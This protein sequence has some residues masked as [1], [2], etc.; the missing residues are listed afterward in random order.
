MYCMDLHVVLPT[1]IIL[2]IQEV[3]QEKLKV[4]FQDGHHVI[5]LTNL[6]VLNAPKVHNKHSQLAQ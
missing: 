6:L 2:L 3:F 5:I 1:Q 4:N